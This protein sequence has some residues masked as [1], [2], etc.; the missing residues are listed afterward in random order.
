MDTVV[1][2]SQE[3]KPTRNGKMTDYM[4]SK[5]GRFLQGNPGGPGR[6]KGS[7][8]IVEAIKRKLEEIPEGQKETYLNIFVFRLFQKAIIEGDTSLMKDIIDRV[9]G[10]AKQNI[11]I[12]IDAGEEERNTLRELIEQV[13]GQKEDRQGDSEGVLQE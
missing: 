8:S 1:Q 2:D 12:D 11:G 4:D 9:D 5:T 6:K 10:R 13:N 3:E 7:I